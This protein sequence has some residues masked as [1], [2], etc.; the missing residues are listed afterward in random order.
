MYSETV[1]LFIKSILAST[2][3]FN[4]VTLWGRRRALPARRT[5]ITAEKGHRSKSD[6]CTRRGVYILVDAPSRSAPRGSEGLHQQAV[7]ESLQDFYRQPVTVHNV[8]QMIEE[9]LC[10]LLLRVPGCEVSPS[11]PLGSVALLTSPTIKLSYEAS[12]GTDVHRGFIIF[13]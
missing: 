5:S 8:S 13:Q 1:S 3:D 12:L 4:F 9:S 6:M 10:C 7:V 11:G 2:T